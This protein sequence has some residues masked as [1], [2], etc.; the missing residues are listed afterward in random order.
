MEELLSKLAGITGGG[1]D[2]ISSLLSSVLGDSQNSEDSQSLPFDPIA[3][4]SIVSA[5][6]ESRDSNDITLLRA[7]KPYLSTSR[8]PK[9]EEAIKVMQIISI[10][11]TIRD[12]G[13]LNS[14]FSGE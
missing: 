11:P 7:L 2:A 3:L 13:L 4:L 12:S 1:E 6:N 9:V 14:F 8:S 5:F 10:W